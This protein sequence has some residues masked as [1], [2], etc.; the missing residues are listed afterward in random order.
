MLCRLNDV[1]SGEGAARCRL[2]KMQL[3]IMVAYNIIVIILQAGVRGRR[4]P[5][6]VTAAY[7]PE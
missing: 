5:M 2:D 7:N 4:V 6:N 1:E 3:L